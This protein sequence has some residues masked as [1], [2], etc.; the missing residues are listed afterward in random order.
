MVESFVGTRKLKCHPGTHPAAVERKQ[1]LH[2]EFR[3]VAFMDVQGGSEDI[4][5]LQ[6]LP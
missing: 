4:W 5:F 3:E 1:Q 2:Q 6:G